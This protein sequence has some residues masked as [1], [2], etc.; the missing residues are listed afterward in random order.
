MVRRDNLLKLFSVIEVGK[1]SSKIIGTLSP[2]VFSVYLI[3][4]HPLFPACFIQGR[5]APLVNGQARY[6][7][8]KSLFII[9]GVYIGCCVIDFIRSLVFKAIIKLF[10]MG[11]CVR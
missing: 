6:L 4:D 11:D 1:I 9:S 2:L 5:F 3:H 8:A 10:K 7:V